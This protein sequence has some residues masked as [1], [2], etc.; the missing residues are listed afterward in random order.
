MRSQLWLRAT[1]TV[2]AGVDDG[3]VC[4]WKVRGSCSARRAVGG[5]ALL[6]IGGCDTRSFRPAAGRPGE[7]GQHIQVRLHFSGLWR[8][9]LSRPPV[10]PLLLCGNHW[11]CCYR[12]NG[13]QKRCK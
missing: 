6:L 3:G 12:G 11:F 5:A 7:T 8:G 1:D 4:F 2:R 13:G 9:H 10:L